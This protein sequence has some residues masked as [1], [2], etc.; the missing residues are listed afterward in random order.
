MSSVL[1]SGRAIEVNIRIFTK[2]R[3]LLNDN[4]SL[5]LEIENK[6][7]RTKVGYKSDKG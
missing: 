2:M 7:E 1:N 6:N 5:R 4:L 3:K